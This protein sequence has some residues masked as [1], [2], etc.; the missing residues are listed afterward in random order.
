MI[1]VELF[2]RLMPDLPRL[3]AYVDLKE[4]A[5]VIDAVSSLGIRSGSSWLITINGVQSEEQ[6]Q[7][8]NCCRLCFFTHMQGG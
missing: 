7:L 2:G 5:V 8:S 6:D 3:H 1:E 4:P